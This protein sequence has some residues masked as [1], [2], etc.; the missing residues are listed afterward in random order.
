M[1]VFTVAR[2]RARSDLEERS[3]IWCQLKDR[4][5]EE[6]TK[7]G[8]S[9][10]FAAVLANVSQPSKNVSTEP[11]IVCWLHWRPCGLP[12]FACYFGAILVGSSRLCFLLPSRLCRGGC[13]QAQASSSSH[14]PL[15][16]DHTSTRCSPFVIAVPTR[17]SF[18]PL[19]VA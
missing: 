16:L 17:T 5:P 18:P 8:I 11:L 15:I 12:S 3:L 9:C 10:T 19:L 14:G 6:R 2:V 1:C 7:H 13:W 4:I